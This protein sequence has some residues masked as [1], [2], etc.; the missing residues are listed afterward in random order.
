[1]CDGEGQRVYV[2]TNIVMILRVVMRYY[3]WNG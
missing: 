1:M 2:H 3:L